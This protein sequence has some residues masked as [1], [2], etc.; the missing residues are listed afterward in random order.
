MGSRVLPC[1]I[2][3][4]KATLLECEEM[5]RFLMVMTL[6]VVGADALIGRPSAGRAPAPTH[7]L[8]ELFTS[9]GCSSCPAADALLQSFVDAQPI[10]GAEVIALGHHVDYW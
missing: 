10:P 7:V 3:L 6:L 5:R 4:T 8:V 2:E 1:W 9:E